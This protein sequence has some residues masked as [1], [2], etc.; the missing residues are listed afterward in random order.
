MFTS[1]SFKGKTVLVTGGTRGIGKSIATSFEKLGATVIAPGKKELNLLDDLSI[2]SFLY[3]L[4]DIDICINNAGINHIN[5]LCDFIDEEWLDIIQVNLTGAYK[6]SKG[7]A[8]GMM[9]RSYGRIINIGSIWGNISKAGRGAYSASKGGLKGL[10][11]AMAAELAEYNILVNMV[12]PGFTLTDMTKK[13][14]GVDGILE[15][16]KTIPIGRL[17]DPGEIAKAVLFLSSDLNTYI[18]GHDLVVDGGFI[19]V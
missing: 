6:I 16:Q 12:S 11:K 10:T 1:D 4:Q 18:S 13:S 2:K 15:V 9:S 14:L 3:D 8:E 7:V 17:A 19:N 5:S